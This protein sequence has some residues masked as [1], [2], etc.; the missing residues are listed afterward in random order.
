MKRLLYILFLFFLP[1]VSIVAQGPLYIVDGKEG[2][3]RKKLPIPDSIA[4]MQVLDSAEAT[5]VYG[6]RASG[7]AV[8][9]Q[10][11]EYM[12]HSGDSILIPQ[13]NMLENASVREKEQKN[14]SRKHLWGILLALL[15][16]WAVERKWFARIA[17]KLKGEPFAANK[18]QIS[19]EQ[20]R[21]ICETEPRIFTPDEQL[22]RGLDPL[23]AD[24]ALYVVMTERVSSDALRKYFG[25][26]VHR[27]KKLMTQLEEEKVIG[28]KERDGS[29]RLLCVDPVDL[30]PV[31]DRLG[32]KWGEDE[33]G[34][35]K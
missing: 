10:T 34:S 31:F 5:S 16:V 35:L 7:G 19:D 25:I 20:Y 23:F 32:I 17:C 4:S 6:K 26:D 3:S 21:K 11:Q 30:N 22:K 27:A 28:H 15:L 18:S 9:I 29:Q 8:I 13:N 24:A 12:R 2:V 1:L 33:V 14:R